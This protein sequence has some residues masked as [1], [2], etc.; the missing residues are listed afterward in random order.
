M[1]KALNLATQQDIIILSPAWTGRLPALRAL[2]RQDLLVCPACRRPVRVRAG[3]TR[4]RHFAHKH[5]E[6]C[7][8]QSASPLLL[9]ARA[10]LY[11]W[12]LAQFGRAERR[13]GAPAGGPRPP[14]AARLPG[15][16]PGRAGRLLDHRAP[17]AAR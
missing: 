10:V 12:L 3:R 13:S 7:P 16:F 4:R 9:E 5:L 6:N 15:N 17:H 11:E 8:Y 1:Y 14:Q 2:D